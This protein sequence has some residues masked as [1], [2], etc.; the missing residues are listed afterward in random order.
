MLPKPIPTKYGSAF[1]MGSPI[2]WYYELTGEPIFLDRLKEMAG[3][4]SLADRCMKVLGN[5][6]Y[7]LYLAQGGK[8]PGRKGLE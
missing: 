4:Q 2:T 6:S 1:Y 8:I 7:S 3:S 5:W